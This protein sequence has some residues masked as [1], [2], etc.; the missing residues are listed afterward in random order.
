AAANQR[1]KLLIV[2]AGN[3]AEALLRELLRTHA[4][5]YE[6]VGLLDD[7]SAKQNESLHGVRVIG[8]IADLA[9]VV[10][11]RGI[12]E[13][14]VAIPSL[15]GRGMRM[16]VDLCRMANVPVRTLPSVDALVDGRVTVERLQNVNIEDLLRRAPV[17]LDTV[18]ISEYLESKRVLVTG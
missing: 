4:A 3:A 16:I 13:V 1:R 18:V 5:R 15:P 10:T 17:R 2:G 12:Q 14:M 7:A 9:E 6:V 8:K 11:A